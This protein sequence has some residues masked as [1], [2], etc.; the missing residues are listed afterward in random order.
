M[1]RVDQLITQSRRA[2]ENQE[3]T[4]SAGIQDEEFLEYLNNAQEEIHS[5][6]QSTFPSILVNISS[7]SAVAGKEAY[8]IPRDVYLGTRIDQLE[9]SQSTEEAY[10]VLRKGSLKE[11]ISVD[12]GVPAFYI[13]NGSQLLIQPRPQ[14]SGLFRISYQRE[15]PRLDVRRGQVSAYTAGAGNTITTL[16]LDTDQAI[17]ATALVEENFITVIDKNGVVK[18]CHIPVTAVSSSTGEVTIEPG[19]VFEDGETIEVGDYVCRGKFSSTTSQLPDVCEKYLLEA[20]N[21]RILMRDSSVDSAEIA[22]LLSRVQETL[23]LAFAEPDNDPSRVP[24][25][26]TEFLGFEE[27]YP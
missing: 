3:F 20:C 14:S 23:R 21:M 15:I 18:M 27:W 10:Y 2:T 16:T 17:D 22:A 1:R 5:V 9:F 6:L 11:R 13:R 8:D 4:D 24:I 19:F 12:R 25:I 26:S 7:F